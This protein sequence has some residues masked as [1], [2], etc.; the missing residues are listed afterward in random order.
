M[1]RTAVLFKKLTFLHILY[2]TVIA[3]AFGQGGNAIV[4]PSSAFPGPFAIDGFLQRQGTAGD[5]AAGPG[6]T[7]NFIFSDNGNTLVPGCFRF[8]DRFNS[9]SDE[10]FSK[11]YFQ[12]NPS[13]MKWDL[14]RAT[15]KTDLNNILGFF[16]L[17]LIDQAIWIILAADRRST[18]KNS[19]IDFEFLQNQVLM[20]GDINSGQDRGF[21]SAGPNGGRTKGDL[22]ISVKFQNS[23]GS[24]AS[25]EYF[26]WQ[27][28]GPDTYRYVPSTFFYT[29][30]TATNSVPINVP[31]G[32]FGSTTYPAFT[33]VETAL[34]IPVVF[35]PPGT[36]PQTLWIKSKSNDNFDDFYP[37]IQLVSTFGS[38][39]GPLSVSYFFYDLYTAQLNASISPLNPADYNFHWTAVGATSGTF[40]D[41]LVTG[42]LNNYDIPDPIFTADTGYNCISYIYK[43]TVSPKNDPGSI[44]AQTNVVINDPC[45]IGKPINPDEMNQGETI[46]EETFNDGDIISVFPNPARSAAA[47]TLRGTNDP[48]DITLIDING[49]VIQRWPATN[50]NNLK[51]KEV[52][53]G[54]YLLRITSKKTGNTIT[55]K[56]VIEN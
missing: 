35:G 47:I 26:E 1:N 45:K 11:G 49:A 54:L 22:L 38:L 41:P 48:K 52:A 25:I 36:G 56:L 20:T 21:Y 50:G 27:Q 24:S 44:V 12:D 7:N 55:K 43:V 10:V 40:V 30:L 14:R 33:F 32:A 23:E 15:S 37:P 13:I 2:L 34:K 29:V 42:S 4:Y 8:F 46:A 39:V 51:L 3:S 6:G 18:G 31:F 16:S 9:A 17:D 53:N 5:W 28:V 19:A